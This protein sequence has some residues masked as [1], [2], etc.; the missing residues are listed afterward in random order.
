MSKLL[1]LARA[2]LPLARAMATPRSSQKTGNRSFMGALPREGCRSRSI[3]GFEG[4]TADH[5]T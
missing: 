4:N 1:S 3:E 5:K 2:L